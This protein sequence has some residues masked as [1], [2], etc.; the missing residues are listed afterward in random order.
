[1]IKLFNQ[2][3]SGAEG[4]RP[5]SNFIIYSELSEFHCSLRCTDFSIKYVLEGTENYQLNGQLYTVKEGQY[6]LSGCHSEGY[7]EIPD[8]KIARGICINITA[9]ILGEVCA[10]LL[11]PGSAFPELHFEHFLTTSDFFDNL[12]RTEDTGLGQFLQLLEPVMSAANHPADRRFFEIPFYYTLAEKILTDQQV[13]YRQLQSIHSIKASTKRDLLKRIS[14]GKYYIDS[15]Y[16]NALDIQTIAREA[17]ISE[18]HFYRLFKVVYG[19]SPYQYILRK[20]LE[21]GYSILQS[22]KIHVSD[23]AIESGFS[24]VYTFSKAFKRYFRIPPSTILEARV[25]HHS[26]RQ[27]V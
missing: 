22:Q 9:A 5:G 10:S 6:L 8:K 2:E 19:V 1:M 24:D 11:K 13:V 15:Y 16:R 23:A 25:M 27:A 17:N 4:I 20:R 3:A 18:Y 14:I 7:A 21:Y 12:Y 26:V